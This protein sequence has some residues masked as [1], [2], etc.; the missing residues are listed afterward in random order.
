MRTLSCTFKR[1]GITFVNKIKYNFFYKILQTNCTVCRGI[2]DILSHLLILP[3]NF[4]SQVYTGVSQL[5]VAL[6]I[7]NC[8]STYYIEVP[9]KRFNYPFLSHCE[10]TKITHFKE[11]FLYLE[12][13]K[14]HDFYTYYINFRKIKF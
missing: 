8:V 7:K 9:L 13:K 4:V 10:L 11:Y 12:K 2:E 5:L 3:Q 14:L 1:L 6:K